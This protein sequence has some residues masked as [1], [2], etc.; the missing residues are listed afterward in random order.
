MHDVRTGGFCLCMGG[1][2]YWCYRYQVVG[3]EESDVKVLSG[4]DVRNRT[5]S[6]YD[7][8]FLAP[9]MYKYS[10]VADFRGYTANCGRGKRTFA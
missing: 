4:V 7:F 3:F 6:L 10:M 1:V 2:V 8:T 5:A 9:D